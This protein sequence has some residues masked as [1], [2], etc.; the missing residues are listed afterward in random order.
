M[1]SLRFSPVRNGYR[2]SVGGDILTFA[3]GLEFY[4]NNNDRSCETG[5]WYKAPFDALRRENYKF[6]SINHEFEA[7]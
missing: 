5:W 2:K 4:W 7:M 1:K 6:S 3:I